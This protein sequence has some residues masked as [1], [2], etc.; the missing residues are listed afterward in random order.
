MNITQ[1]LA[2]ISGLLITLSLAFA[3]IT[4]HKY[5][6]LISLVGEAQE[7]CFLCYKPRLGHDILADEARSQSPEVTEEEI[8]TQTFKDAITSTALDPRHYYMPALLLYF[9]DTDPRYP[10]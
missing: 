5:E 1:F 6:R 4:F 7:I 3:Y 9:P 10:G 8:W 2:L